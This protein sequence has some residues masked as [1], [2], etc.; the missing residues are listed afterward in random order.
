[1][2][3]G[4]WTQ[5]DDKYKHRA[6]QPLSAKAK[7]HHLASVSAF[8]RDIQEWGWIPRR[9][10]PRRSL[11]AP[12][13]LRALIGPK[14]K[15]I[16]DDVWAKLLWAGPNLEEGD[17]TRNANGAHFYPMSMVKAVTVVWLF[18]GLRV[19]EI[20]R[21]RVGCTRENWSTRVQS[22]EAP[23]VCN[24]DCSSL[25][26][27]GRIAKD[28]AGLTGFASSPASNLSNSDGIQIANAATP[29]S[30]MGNLGGLTKI[31]AG[32]LALTGSNYINGLTVV[33]NIGSF[34]FTSRPLAGLTL[35]GS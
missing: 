29:G 26:D 8:F 15:V 28:L 4:D 30:L 12:R 25:P 24:L 20:Q 35:C 19:D 22:A 3:C 6:G 33:S 32:T 11:A 34:A 7:A 21:L 23:A 14:P 27:F 31:G 2:T 9:F 5:I 16:A 13:S 17:L 1:M 10:D 18:C